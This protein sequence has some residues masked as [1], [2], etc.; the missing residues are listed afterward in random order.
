[1]NG[2]LT[3]NAV[4]T[5]ASL[6]GTVGTT[7]LLSTINTELNNSDFFGSIN[8]LMSRAR[9]SFVT[10]I[11][12]PIR[13]VG[14]TVK[15]LVNIVD[16][17]ERYIPITNEELMQR[18]PACMFEPILFYKPIRKMFNE[19]RIFGFGYEYVPTEDCYERLINNGNVEDVRAAM[20]KEQFV[21]FKY[22]F[23]SDDPDLTFDELESIRETREYIDWVLEH[24]DYDPTDYPNTRG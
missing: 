11:I 15:N 9:E 13:A 8:D 24:T 21:E 12:Q 18:V 19:G 22:E 7:N 1:M 4:P 17:D 14:N 10:N 20:D 2:A 6:V 16:Y 23:Q 3:F 5:L